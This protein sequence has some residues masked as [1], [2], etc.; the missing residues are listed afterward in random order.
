MNRPSGPIRSMNGAAIGGPTAA[1]AAQ[2]SRRLLLTPTIWSGSAK[3]AA[4]ATAT[5]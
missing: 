4:C 2:A 5:A 1:P 3:S